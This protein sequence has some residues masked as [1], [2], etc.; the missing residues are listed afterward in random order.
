MT[1][2]RIA[3]RRSLALAA[4]LA[5][6]ASLLAVTGAQAS[7][8][9][10]PIS[11]PSKC[12][13][14]N[15]AQGT[16]YGSLQAAVDE[17]SAGATLRVTGTCFGNTIIHQSLTIA[18][19]SSPG[20]DPWHHDRGR[21]SVRAVLDGQLAGPVV[22]IAPVG[23]PATVTIRNL[24]IT[25]GAGTGN[26]GGIAICPSACTT[27]LPASLTLIRSTVVDNSAPD[28][29]GI[30][31]GESG[32]LIMDRGSVVTGNSATLGGGISNSHG[33]TLVLNGRSS[34][35]HN[36]AASGGGIYFATGN[37]PAV[38]LNGRSSVHDN[39]A[40][41]DG[42]GIYIAD[43]GVE[44]NDSSSIHDNAAAR[45]GGIFNGTAG[46]TTING[47]GSIHDN[48]ATTGGGGIWKRPS[49][50]LANCVAGVNVLDNT[51]DDIFLEP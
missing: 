12:L 29:G 31:I 46:A 11:R 34:V 1:T 17:A 14:V 32:T 35:D 19:R 48:T 43:A 27:L 3:A 21:R 30:G 18:G 15:A 33:G 49:S 23:V 4:A 7:S 22:S 20:R 51:P 45:G 8:S 47:H 26:G 44:L 10:K 39:T 5:L 16:R 40:S 37:Y 36:S 50:S 9:T 2:A 24:V 6:A 28:G 38:V 13:V 41:A 25:H 42:G